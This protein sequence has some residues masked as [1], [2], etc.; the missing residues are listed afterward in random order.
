MPAFAIHRITPDN[1]ALL[2]RVADDVF[3]EFVKPEWL[4]PYLASPDHALFAALANDVVIGQARAVLH[5][6]PDSAAD[7]YID[8]LG[9]AP[10]HKRQGVA[11]ALVDALVAWGKSQADCRSIWLA[12]EHD[13]DE[14]KGFYDAA[15]FI[16]QSVLYCARDFEPN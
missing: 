11:R 4:G 10:A 9:V 14:G 2:D 5:R 3:D 16:G 12:T 8:N 6:Q 15:G 1:A 7:I 13:N